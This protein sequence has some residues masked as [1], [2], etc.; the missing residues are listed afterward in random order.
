M[1]KEPRNKNI[2]VQ[3]FTFGWQMITALG[4]AVYLGILADRRLHTTMPLL[5]WIL[6]LLVIVGMMVKVIKDTTKK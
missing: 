6:P 4:I 2:L 3:Y 1:D 5:V